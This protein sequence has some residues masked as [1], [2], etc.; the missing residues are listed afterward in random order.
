RNG[1]TRRS[2][3]GMNQPFYDVVFRANQ[4]L[5]EGKLQSL[6]VAVQDEQ[7]VAIRPLGS[8]L[9]GKRIIELEPHQVLLPGLVDTHVHVNEP[10]RTEWEGFET[11]T[12]AAAAGGVTTLID[13]PLNSVPSTVNTEALQ[14]KQDAARDQLLI[15]TGSWG[16]AV[17]GYAT[18]L[19]PIHDAGVF[20]FKG[21]L[22]QSSVEDFPFGHTEAM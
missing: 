22:A 19:K 9:T 14:I 18:E 20:G 5:F 6:E 13:M 12:R 10:G 2:G 17:A 7:I 16:G 15:D 3:S 1:T 8:E 4:T 11:A 21:F